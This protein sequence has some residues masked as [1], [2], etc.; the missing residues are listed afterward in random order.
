MLLKKATFQA[1]LLLRII[2]GRSETGFEVLPEDEENRHEGK[3][4]ARQPEIQYEHGPDDKDCVETSLEGIRH[5]ARSQ[6]RHLINVL[7]HAVELLT[8]RRCFVVVGGEAVHL[9]EDSQS[10]VENE[11]LHCARIDQWPEARETLPRHI[12]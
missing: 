3:D 12:A 10:N 2:R 4:H 11:I 7:F 8:H 6:F 9:L 5:E 1:G